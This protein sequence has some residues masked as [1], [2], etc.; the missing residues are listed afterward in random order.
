M[1]F[2]Q[3]EFDFD[4]PGDGGG[5]RRWRERLDEER[6]RFERRWG[7]PLGRRVRIRIEG[8]ARSIVGRIELAQS[9]PSHGK[10]RL[11]IGSLEFTPEEIKSVVRKDD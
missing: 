6:L 10:P 9:K 1:S 11:R 3:G 4:A 8:H 7:V 5:Y 2:D